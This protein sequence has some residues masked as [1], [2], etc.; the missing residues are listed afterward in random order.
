MLNSAPIAALKV[1]SISQCKMWLI[2]PA[3]RY[4]ITEH[5]FGI[6]INSWQHGM[7]LFH[8]IPGKQ[9]GIQQWE[10]LVLLAVPAWQSWRTEEEEDTES[11]SLD[12]GALCFSR[13]MASALGTQHLWDIMQRALSENHMELFSLQ[14]CRKLPLFWICTEL[15]MFTLCSHLN[16]TQWRHH[17]NTLHMVL[18]DAIFMYSHELW[19]QDIHRFNFIVS[20]LGFLGDDSE[21]YKDIWILYNSTLKVL[22]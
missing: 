9:L 13:G 8:K 17:P 18:Y 21:S 11:S 1:L 2:F 4:L 20:N 10:W 12:V 16:T 15:G 6:I 22:V 14:T 3:A 7:L 5:I 19:G